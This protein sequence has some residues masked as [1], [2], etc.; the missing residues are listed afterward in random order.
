MNAM[1]DARLAARLALQ[2]IGGALVARGV[3]DHATW[4][5]AAGLA[6]IVVGFWM[7]RRSRRKLRE[8]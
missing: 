1:D 4:E 7:S 8:G 5:A 6:S 2:V 3:G